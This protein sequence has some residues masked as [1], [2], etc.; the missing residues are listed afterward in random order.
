MNNEET[1]ERMKNG[2]LYYCDS[3]KLLDEQI[4]YL[5]MQWEYNSTRPSEKGRREKLLESMFAEIGTDCYIE[6]PLRAN[7]GGKNVHFADHIYANI[8]L[9]MVDDSDIYVGS[10]VMFGPNVTL[11]TGTHPISPK[12][13]RKGVQYNLSLTIKEN[14]WIGANVVILPGVTIGENSVIGAGSIVTKDIPPNTIA[15][16]NPC[17]VQR[18]ITQRDEKYYNRDFEIDL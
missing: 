12:L 17:K 11:V 15:F 13:R 14:V 4:K 3:P 5:D 9:T 6:P 8:N 1:L 18:E 2:K 7:W 10:H 16:G